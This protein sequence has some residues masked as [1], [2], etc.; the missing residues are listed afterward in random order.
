MPGRVEKCGS[1]ARVR[2][3]VRLTLKR[4]IN[5]STSKYSIGQLVFTHTHMALFVGSV[6]SNYVEHPGSSASPLCVYRTEDR[7]V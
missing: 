3:R 5:V 7:C 2:V 1:I 6:V 4:L